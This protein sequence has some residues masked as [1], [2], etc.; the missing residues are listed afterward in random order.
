[1]CVMACII[2]KA[3]ENVVVCVCVCVC[4]VTDQPSVPMCSNTKVIYCICADLDTGTIIHRTSLCP[5]AFLYKYA[6]IISTCML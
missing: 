5:P 1:M 6:L 2:L 4:C 3:T